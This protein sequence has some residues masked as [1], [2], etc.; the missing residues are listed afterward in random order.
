MVKDI[1]FAGGCF[2]GVEQ[3]AKNIMGVIATEVG[4]ANGV[5]QVATYENLKV[6]D[7]AETVKITYDNDIITLSFLL[8]LL[9]KVVDPTSLNKQGNDIGRQYRSGIYYVDESDL[10][11]INE[12]MKRLKKEYGDVVVEV[13]PLQNYITA[14]VY[15]QDYLVKNPNG[16]CHIDFKAIQDVK[17]IK[18]D[19]YKYKKLSDTDMKDKL[20]NEA[21][22][23]VANS[24][25]ERP[26]TSEFDKFDEQGIYVD[27][28]SGEPL[29]SSLDKYDAGCGWPSFTKPIDINSVVEISD[30]SHNMI[31]TE[32]RSRVNDSHLG[33]V[34]NDGPKDAGGLRYCINGAALRFVSYNDMDKEGYGYLK[35]LFEK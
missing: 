21:Y 15:H 22:D 31:R 7:H 35:V 5:T 17:K 30:K 18:V 26:F 11:E 4:Y 10:D 13:E 19:P 14:E 16:Y 33:H 6:S 2:W 9:F 3:Y 24:A 20:D 29:F 25:T 1:Y 27:I 8:E 34:F 32:T 23:V 12:V 28:A